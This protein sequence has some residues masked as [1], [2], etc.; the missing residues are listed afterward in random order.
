M[1]EEGSIRE[2]ITLRD[3][4]SPALQ[5]IMKVVNKLSQAF[6][7]ATNTAVDGLED[8][9]KA[10]NSASSDMDG[11]SSK[12]LGIAG[13]I[14]AAF[15]VRELLAASDGVS[16]VNARLGLLTQGAEDSAAALDDLQNKVYSSAMATRSSFSE[17][18]E[19]VAKLGLMAGDAFSGNDELVAFSEQMNKL[20][21]IGGASAEEQA[22]ATQ[23]LVQGLAAGALRGDELNSVMEQAP[24]AIQALS[25]NLGVSTG[26]IRTLAA[27]GKITADVFKNAIL[28]QAE[29]TNEMFSQLPATWSD[30]FTMATN[31][32]QQAFAPLLQTVSKAA[33]WITENW[34]TILPVIWRAGQAVL[35][36][37]AAFALYKG[38]QMAV[39]AAT[40]AHQIA[41]VGL[42]AALL[43]SPI[44]WITLIIIG[45]VAAIYGVV[46]ALNKWAGTT[47]SATGVIMG[48]LSTLGAFIWN[49]FLGILEVVFGVF[50][51]LV[52]P[53]LTFVNFFGNVFNAPVSSIINLFADLADNVLGFLEK[54]AS[55]LDMVFGS[56]MAAS[57]ASWRE[58]IQGMADNLIKEYAP[59]EEYKEVI[60]K[61]NL[62]VDDLGLGRLGY[63][64]AYNSG[65][66]A[67][68]GLED[69]FSLPDMNSIIPQEPFDMG[70]MPAMTE[71]AA[72]TE[73]MAGNMEL[74][75]ES[76]KY[77]RDIAEREVIN[78]LTTAEIKMEMVNNNNISSELDIDGV[79]K[80]F[81][82][83]IEESMLA[84]AEGAR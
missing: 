25:E 40:W 65:Y 56:N 38:I 51:Q 26:E 46:A 64:D 75:E 37:A 39:T 10:A 5:K 84:M 58:G 34:S 1:A 44:T 9:S 49:L 15:G 72:N 45:I 13:A 60:S 74:S 11:L 14:G 73:A 28:S 41:Q 17:T 69:M 7:G 61:L 27:E 79:V 19:S 22:N 77:L 83:G 67:G 16:Q 70:P 21:K 68:E 30:V 78:K 80:R 31:M 47:I 53:I 35:A 23:Q 42:N 24:M 63:G 66:S 76:L 48:T 36:L 43:A 4:V 12:L 54:I 55:G 2:T 82:E 3:N 52:N 62:G 57:V 18:A 20:F 33:G 81:E 32:A 59:E 50:A 6:T 8:V 29:K 71:T